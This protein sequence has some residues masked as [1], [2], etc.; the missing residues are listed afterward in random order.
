MKRR[1][2]FGALAGLVAALPVTAPPVVTPTDPPSIIPPPTAGPLSTLAAGFARNLGS[3]W[4]GPPLNGSTGPAYHRSD[5]SRIT[6]DAA[7][8][9]I[10][11][12]G[13]GHGEGQLADIRALDLS[14]LQWSS[15]YPP[16]P[17]ADMV[18]A[19]VT[20]YGAWKVGA[21]D[22]IPAARHSYNSSVVQGGRLYLFASNA[23]FY[24]E[25]INGPS[26]P[27]S[28][29]TDTRLWWFDFAKA[30]WECSQNI[31]TVPW[32]YACAACAIPHSGK[33]LIVAGDS[34]G[35]GWGF[36]WI[37]DPLAD[38]ATKIDAFPH[39]VFNGTPSL[40][41]FP[42]NGKFYALLQDGA[43][44]EITCNGTTASSVKLVT[45]GTYVVG[46]YD[47]DPVNRAI[48][49]AT[50][51]GAYTTFDPMGDKTYKP[52]SLLNE[53]GS[54]GT[55]DAV[56][57]CECFEPGGCKIVL[58]VEDKMTWA[59]RP[60]TFGGAAQLTPPGSDL[61]QMGDDP[62]LND[63]PNWQ[64]ANRLLRVEWKHPGGDWRD[65]SNASQGGN[66][67]A[68]SPITATGDVVIECTALVQRLLAENTGVYINH[69]SG[70]DPRFGQ[71][72][73]RVETKQ[74]TVN[75]LPKVQC[76]LEPSSPVLPG[77]A[78]M[79]SPAIVKFDLSS[80]RGG[81]NKATL[82]LAMLAVGGPGTLA[83][84]YL[85]PPSMALSGPVV[86]GIAATV[87][88]D[89][90]LAAHRSVLIY[91]EF[92]SPQY[93]ADNFQGISSSTHGV[94][95]IEII[96]WPQYGLK[97]ARVWSA[98]N[99]E[100]IISW[101]HWGIPKTYTP[102]RSWQRD[103]GDGFTHLFCRYCLRIGEDVQAGMTESGIKLPGLSGTFDYSSSGA[104]TNPTPQ[105]DRWNATLWH[106][107]LG[108][109]NAGRA[110]LSVYYF[111]VDKPYDGAPDT[112]TSGILRS[113]FIHCIEEEVKLNTLKDPKLAT[114]ANANADGEIRI[115]LDGVRVLEKTGMVIRID[116]KARIQDMPFM[117][118]Y[119]GGVGL[120]PK[121]RFHYDIGGLA[122]ATQYIG[123]PKVVA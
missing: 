26:P 81:V 92:T 20:P 31:T 99:N 52:I 17:W 75:L 23:F 68:L 112:P 61:V 90:A 69:I 93:V 27:S 111:G 11:F 60:K 58:G 116:D 15:L 76:Y 122:I 87:A 105:G 104:P 88:N 83:L 106:G 55:P 91:D 115:W 59:Y 13:G 7:H 49:G 70:Q 1:S 57:F 82:T 108:A 25:A 113:G 63:G 8:N 47:Y 98:T 77:S 45:S 96:A 33:S 24:V 46:A 38:T 41:Y 86:Q 102:A 29:F 78:S 5:Y 110:R 65:K 51:G 43:V 101:H 16:V 100:K 97:A 66:H 53:A 71:P 48:S 30:K 39:Q 12:F 109:A 10:L 36:A 9:R 80:V 28:Y 119:H 40:V 85:D 21:A 117:L 84:D 3:S 34:S 123:P 22:P 37:Y 54:I 114:R 94:S 4:V 32:H 62:A 56:F 2:F 50:H 44:Y 64:Y 118:M 103:Y 74:G 121:T 120:Y 35:S 95:N 14:T 19:N 79:R 67:Y 42:P 6:L 89:K 107:R 72:R 73:L 18:A